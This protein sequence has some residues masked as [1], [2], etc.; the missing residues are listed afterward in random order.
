MKRM[1]N[2]ARVL[3]LL[4]VLC[5]VLLPLVACKKQNVNGYCTV[6]VATEPET[7]Y[8]VDLDKLGTVE[9]GLMSVLDYLK[10]NEG[11]TYES[12]DTGYGA[13]LTKILTLDSASITNGFITL[14]TSV[15]KDFDVTEYA[16]EKDY[17]G[18]KVVTSGLGASSMTIQADAIYYIALSSY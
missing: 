4:L 16:V 12:N 6:V 13:F 17:K 8:T 1:K 15:E 2:A 18:T 11:L 10:A 3:T 14:L 5:M 7:V 9:N